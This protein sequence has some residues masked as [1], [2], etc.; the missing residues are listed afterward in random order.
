MVREIWTENYPLM[1]GGIENEGEAKPPN[2]QESPTSLKAKMAIEAIKGPKTTA[3]IA[4][5]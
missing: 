5:T 3:Q 4:I 2:A 1:V